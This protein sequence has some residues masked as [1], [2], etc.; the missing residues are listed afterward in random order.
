MASTDFLVSLTYWPNLW[1]R[2]THNTNG[3]GYRI[4]EFRFSR[5]PPTSMRTSNS[6]SNDIEG[7][8]LVS[9]VRDEMGATI[10]DEHVRSLFT[11]YDK[12]VNPRLQ[13]KDVND[14]WNIFLKI[15]NSLW[16][17]LSYWPARRAYFK[18]VLNEFY[19]DGVQYFEVRAGLS[20]VITKQLFKTFRHCNINKTEVNISKIGFHHVVSNDSCFLFIVFFL[21]F[22]SPYNII[23]LAVLFTSISCC[24]F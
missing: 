15:F 10:Y 4:E 22:F 17:I 16:P 21:P 8:R 12:N 20:E 6:S 14:V 23:S 9:D 7:W 18:Q 1:Q 19:E 11:L 13:F 24:H 2:G 3:T 5:M